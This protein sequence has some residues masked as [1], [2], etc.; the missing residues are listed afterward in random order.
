[1]AGLWNVGFPTLLGEPV[2]DGDA[3][4]IVDE[5]VRPLNPR[6]PKNPKSQF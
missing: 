3:R 4:L 1:M 5:T 2:S 6:H